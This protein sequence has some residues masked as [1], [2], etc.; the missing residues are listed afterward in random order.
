METNLARLTHP[1]DG[2]MDNLHTLRDQYG[3]DIVVLLT[4]TGGGCGMVE[5]IEAS[6]ATA[7]AV[8]RVG[9]ELNRFTFTHEIGH[10]FG[11]EHELSED[12]FYP[13]EPYCYN[14]GLV[15][16]SRNWKTVMAVKSLESITR[17]AFLSNAHYSYF[18][19]G[20]YEV[21]G[22]SDDEDNERVHDERAT[23]VAAFKTAPLSVNISGPIAL[24]K[25]ETGTYTANV[26]GGHG[27]I[28]YQWYKRFPPGTY[29]ITLGTNQTQNL[30]MAIN[31]VI[32]KVVVIS[33]GQQAEDTQYVWYE[34]GGGPLPKRIANL[35]PD[36]YGL[37]QNHPNPFNPVT[38]LRYD[39]P[40]ASRVS[41]GIYDLS[42]RALSRWESDEPPG[43]RQVVWDGLD[44]SG[45]AAPSGIYIYRLVA[46]S[47]ETGERFVA[48]RKMV[49]LR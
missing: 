25:A 4:A 10:L 35:L 1:S 15:P 17:I 13:C 43:Y 47:I 3:A 34:S 45:Q 33:G 7:F 26:T 23:T 46:T 38:A 9:C 48:S 40:Q 27:G 30:S 29:W 19:E 16:Q 39:L 24:L 11:S 20:I 8:V 36:T 31:D 44:A 28:A 41:L 2:Y 37:H 14:H 42:G 49:L 12:P 6:A 18:T 21:M 5:Y 32:M 22:S